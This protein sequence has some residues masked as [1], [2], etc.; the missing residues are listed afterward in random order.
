MGK[1]FNF[2]LGAFLGAA[3]GA[4]AGVML[5]PRAGAES[6]AMAADA[7]NDAW[8][9]AVDGYERGTK[10]VADKVAE[11][12]AASGISSDELREKVDAARV[13]M[14]ELRTS[15]SDAVATASAQV[16]DVMNT[17]TEQ[18]SSMAD[19][20]ADANGTPAEAVRV[21]VVEDTPA[22]TDAE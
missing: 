8:D 19:A 22:E 1:K 17:V 11:V 14:D 18:V 5:A 9:T 15:L 21:E 13:R 20:A 2:V 12:A 10:T 6:R 7:M 3:A 4:A 16:V